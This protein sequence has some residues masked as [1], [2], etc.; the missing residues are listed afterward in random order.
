MGDNS[1]KF[2]VVHQQHL[3]IGWGLDDEGIET[4]LKSMAGF[5]ARTISDLGHQD[6]TLVLSSNSVINTTWLPPARLKERIFV[7][8]W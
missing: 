5:L 8:E 6:G 4:V 2:I 7:G 1:S 3:K